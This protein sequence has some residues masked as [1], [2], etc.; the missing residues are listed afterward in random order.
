MLFLPELKSPVV[1]CFS[2]PV[3]QE[4]LQWACSSPHVGRYQVEPG[5]GVISEPR[6]RKSLS[7]RHFSLQSS[8]S[9][10]LCLKTSSS[11]KGVVT[12]LFSTCQL[13]VT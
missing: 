11:T 3:F 6:S 1:Q 9:T 12:C 4:Y 7:L 8:F 13:G 2:A 10:V 5:H